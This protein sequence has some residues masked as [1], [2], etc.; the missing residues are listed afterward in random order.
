METKQKQQAR[1]RSSAQKSRHKRKQYHAYLED[2]V[3]GADTLVN[4]LR[5]VLATQGELPNST[6]VE[7]MGMVTSIAKTLELAG[8]SKPRSRAVKPKADATPVEPALPKWT[9]GEGIHGGV[10]EVAACEAAQSAAQSA[11]EEQLA[12]FPSGLEFLDVDHDAMA[13][14]AA[15][16]KSTAK[17]AF[18]RR[19]PRFKPAWEQEEEDDPAE[20][21]PL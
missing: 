15:M 4:R 10:L 17:K 6:R 18:V 13:V 14:G 3:V 16:A 21:V 1:N 20:E 2:L 7:L 5:A 8:K 19:S 12:P 11:L 9:P